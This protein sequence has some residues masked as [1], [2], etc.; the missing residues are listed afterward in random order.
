MI[1]IE[2]KWVVSELRCSAINNILMLL[3]RF[4]ITES[5]GMFTML[6]YHASDLRKDFAPF[7]LDVHLSR[8][9]KG[10]NFIVMDLVIELIG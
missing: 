5:A 2:R 6:V 3:S 7:D 9:V 1:A 4:F 8:F 10:E